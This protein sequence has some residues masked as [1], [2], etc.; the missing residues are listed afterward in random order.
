MLPRRVATIVVFS[1]T[2]PGTLQL[3]ELNHAHKVASLD[4]AAPL[5]PA[6]VPQTLPPPAINGGAFG[7]N[8]GR[9]CSAVLGKMTAWRN[10]ARLTVMCTQAL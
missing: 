8:G 4:G 7:S 6:A 1:D 2:G 9:A 3:L 10:N 5:S